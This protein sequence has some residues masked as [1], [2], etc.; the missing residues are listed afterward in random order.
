[1]GQECYRK[2]LLSNESFDVNEFASSLCMSRTTLFHKI[3]DL[4]GLTPNAFILSV[5][6]RRA[7]SEMEA[8][9]D[10]NISSLAYK[11]GFAT[12]SYFIKC[13]KRYYGKTPLEFKKSVVLTNNKLPD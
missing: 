10:E 8:N 3:K 9:P 2:P 5:K 7:V 13:F 1:M 12:P 11:C 4:T 6:L